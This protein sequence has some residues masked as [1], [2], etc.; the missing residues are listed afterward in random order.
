MTLTPPKPP[1]LPARQRLATL[2]SPTTLAQL[3]HLSVRWDLPLGRVI[4]RLSCTFA[5]ADAELCRSL[6]ID[7]YSREHLSQNATV[8]VAADHIFAGQMVVASE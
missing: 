8:K 6:N 2:V 7:P 1:K 5:Q 4:D 3:H